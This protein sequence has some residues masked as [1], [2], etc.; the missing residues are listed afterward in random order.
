MRSSGR[1]A[2]LIVRAVAAACRPG[3]TTR[4]LDELARRLITEHSAEP[5]LLG[6]KSADGVEF[7]GAACLCVNEEVV[8]AVPSDRIVRSGDVVTVD[9]AIRDG[10]G[11]CADAATTVAVGGLGR[12]GPLVNLAQAA[13]AGAIKTA[14]PG[15]LWSS[16]A[17]AAAA[18]VE[19]AGCSLVAGYCG[20]GIGRVMHEQPRLCFG[21]ARTAARDGVRLEPG[22]VLTLEPI[23]VEGPPTEMVTLDDGWTVVASNRSWAAHEERTIA[24]TRRGCDILTG[25]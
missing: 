22:M 1:L 14:A 8:H 24:I 12:A 16:V 11:W 9:I 2:W 4:E 23:V 20:H 3:V 13:V 18:L 25:P 7:P 15:V 17:E 21:S 10:A 5:L 6:Y 19:R